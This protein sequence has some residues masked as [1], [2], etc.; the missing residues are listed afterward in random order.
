MTQTW[1]DPRLMHNPAAAD[2]S[3]MRTSGGVMGGVGGVGS[4]AATRSDADGSTQRLPFLDALYHADS[5]WM[6]RPYF[7]RRGPR[8]QGDESVRVFGNGTVEQAIRWDTGLD[9]S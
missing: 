8:Q 4:G 7:R 6:P 3:A 1:F 5:I 2:S 9:I